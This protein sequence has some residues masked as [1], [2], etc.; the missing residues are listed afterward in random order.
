MVPTKIHSPAFP[1]VKVELQ[2]DECFTVGRGLNNSLSLPD[3]MFENE[4]NRQYNKASREHFKIHVE[5]GKLFLTNTSAN[6]T[7][8]NRIKVEKIFLTHGDIISLMEKDFEMFHFHVDLIKEP[9][10]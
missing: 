3:S 2:G 4:E 7:F 1:P 9:S 8:V 10:K 5:C 6:R